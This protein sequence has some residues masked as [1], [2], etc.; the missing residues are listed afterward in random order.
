[1]LIPLWGRRASHSLGDSSNEP[2]PLGVHLARPI[3]AARES[4]R[5]SGR[6]LAAGAAR[7]GDLWRAVKQ[8]P[9]ARPR[10]GQ[11]ATAT[12]RKPI[13]R[14]GSEGLVRGGAWGRAN[15]FCLPAPRPAP[16]RKIVANRPEIT[17][18]NAPCDRRYSNRASNPGRLP[19]APRPRSCDL[20]AVP[21]TV[22]CGGLAT[23]WVLLAG[24]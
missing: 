20:V 7:W 21:E 9:A 22:A 18:S 5:A 15:E 14:S 3:F 12:R 1:M 19:G 10:F 2:E 16:H 8:E 11:A 6:A 17:R 4:G 23:W 13:A 24:P